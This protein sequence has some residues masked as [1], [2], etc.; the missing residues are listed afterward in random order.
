MVIHQIQHRMSEK[1]VHGLAMGI[2]TDTFAFTVFFLI[3][4]IMLLLHALNMM[5][6]QFFLL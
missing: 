6:N 1:L 5:V 4:S 2:I 3:N